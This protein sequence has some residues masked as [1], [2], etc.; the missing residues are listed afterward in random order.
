MEQN[1]QSGGQEI[2]EKQNPIE[3]ANKTL[4]EIRKYEKKNYRLN[5]FRAFCSA[6]CLLL[7]LGIAAYLFING[8]TLMQKA[9]E[10]TTTVSE[11]G[12]HFNKVAEDLE[13]VEFEKLGKSMQEIADISKDTVQQANE[14][15]GGLDKIVQTADTAIENL[16]GLKIDELNQGI[17]ELNEVVQNLKKIFEKFKF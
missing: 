3:P 13:K 10:I 2:R 15:A 8:Q 6:V 12:T 16:S 5:R 1:N 11:A 14:A 9:D 17:T 7:C 4:E